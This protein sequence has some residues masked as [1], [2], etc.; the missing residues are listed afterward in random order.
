MCLLFN[1]LL[2]T[3]LELLANQAQ[4]VAAGASDDFEKTQ[5]A[6]KKKIYI[7]NNKKI[8]QITRKKS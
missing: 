4:F 2:S 8:E 6:S 5:A 3:F 7:F 1:R